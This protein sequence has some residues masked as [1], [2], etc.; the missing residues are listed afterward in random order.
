MTYSLVCC[1]KQTPEQAAV[2][3]PVDAEPDM[4]AVVVVSPPSYRNISSVSQEDRDTVDGFRARGREFILG[5]SDPTLYFTQEDNTISGYAVLL[6]EWFSAVFEIPFKPRFYQA[7]AL[8]AGL[9]THQIDFSVPQSSTAFPVISTGNPAL[10]PIIRIAELALAQGGAEQLAELRNKEPHEYLFSALSDT[11]RVPIAETPVAETGEPLLTEQEPDD[12]DAIQALT[13]F[14]T[15][16]NLVIIIILFATVVVLVIFVLLNAM[17]YKHLN[18]YLETTINQ[19]TEQLEIQTKIAQDRAHELEIQAK[20]SQV[21]SQVKS[22]FLTRISHE[23]RAPLNAIMGMTESARKTTLSP[24]ILAWLDQISTT[25]T[26]LLTIL[27][28]LLDMSK[29]ESGKFVLV[30]KPLLL[31]P[32]ILEVASIV[33]PRCRDKQIHFLTNVREL[34]DISILSDKLR[35]KQVLINLLDNSVNLT[36]EQGKLALVVKVERE[37]N[38]DVAI[39]FRVTDSGIGMSGDQMAKIF[40]PLEQADASLAPRFAGTGLGLSI[41]QSLVAQMGGQIAVKSN[42]GKGSSFS[43]TITCEKTQDAQT[44]Q[45]EQIIRKPE[46]VHPPMNRALV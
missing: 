7:N 6:C 27:N 37:T 24:K 28:D 29:I 31:R 33:A 41:S 22:D 38:R 32:T 45:D 3:A 34:P 10:S 4:A 42:P 36:P 39:M 9:E 5:V 14:L 8:T 26:H 16:Y 2:A 11:D 18:K 30:H 17:R 23:I 44:E 25:S 15:Q 13:S 35:L 12:I 40:N 1:T 20:V 19:R 46:L 43:F 21:A